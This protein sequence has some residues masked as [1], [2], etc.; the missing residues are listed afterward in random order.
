MGAGGLHFH[1]G[2]ETL[3]AVVIGAVLATVGG[4]AATQLEAFMRRRER[5]RDAA[6]LFGEILSVLELIIA[7]ADEARG[8]GAPYGPLTMRLLR[9]VRR[10]IEAYDRNRESLYDLRDPK[11][12]GQ[13][14]ALMVRVTIALE[15]VSETTPEITAAEAAANAI[16]LDDPAKAEAMARLGALVEIRETA[17]EAAV[18]AVGQI[19]PVVSA[20][21]PLA[22][23]NFGAYASVVRN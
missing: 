19:K 16:G 17:F 22:K 18:E 23:Q 1:S 12:R 20:L 15:A 9:A 14:H 10:E 4:F 2:E 13:I 5:E 11:V 6:L 7:M 3:W 8:R 21:Q